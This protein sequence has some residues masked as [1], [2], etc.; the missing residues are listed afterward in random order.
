MT[1]SPSQRTRRSSLPSPGQDQAWIAG[2]REGQFEIFHRIFEVYTPELGRF[3]CL[4]VPRDVAEDI[5]QDVMFDLWQR[6]EAIEFRDG[7]TPYLFG[8]VRKKI[9]MYLRHERI[10]HRTEASTG[11]G[12]VTPPG[13]G[14]EPHAPDSEV[15]IDDLQQALRDFCRRLSP[16]Q[17]EILTLRWE[18]EMSYEQIAQTLSISITAAQ[19]HGSR[20]QRA[21]R[22]LLVRFLSQNK[23]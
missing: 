15:L 21:I 14:E 17:R 10:V 20:A 2:L 5:V 6:R 19:Q 9:S 11:G 18:H 3:A 13:M 1:I 23:S 12:L 22:P 8:A 4:S 7:L 16:I